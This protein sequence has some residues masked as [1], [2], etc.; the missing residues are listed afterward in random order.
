MSSISA[1]T[2]AGSALVSA[3]DTTGDLIL[4]VNGTTPSV[5]LAANG[6]IGVGSTPSYGTAG[7]AL[8]SGGSGA[9]PSWGSAGA[10]SLVSTQ[11]AS[12][13]ATL[14][15]S[16]LSGS[17]KYILLGNLKIDA[18]GTPAITFGTGA[19]PT[20]ISSG[21]VTGTIQTNNSSGN[22]QVNGQIS[23]SASF[24][25]G[26]GFNLISATFV[27]FG[28]EFLLSGF[29]LNS[30]TMTGTVTSANG[31]YSSTT[32][33]IAATGGFIAMDS[34]ATPI[35]AI[36]LTAPNVFSYGTVS[37]YRVNQ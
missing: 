2:S 17:D 33:Y 4:R 30:P 15:F 12:N 8:L 35:T 13:S 25:L 6:S 3:G 26:R 27:S 34:T 28:F 21:Y 32:G 1:G 18:T 10:Y 19:G 11:T 16:G 36:R 29:T 20:F 37:L 7:Q 5:S 31:S 9:A 22:S 23:N 24:L 14:T